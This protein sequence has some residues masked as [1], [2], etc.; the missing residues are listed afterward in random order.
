[1]KSICLT[2][3]IPTHQPYLNESTPYDM[4]SKDYTQSFDYEKCYHKEKRKTFLQFLFTWEKIELFLVSNIK[5]DN[6][7][8]LKG[9][10]YLPVKLY[11]VSFF[12]L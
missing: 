3:K 10:K 11:A 2:Y 4:L 6:S 9:I 1:M 7:G 8:K 5:R 12:V